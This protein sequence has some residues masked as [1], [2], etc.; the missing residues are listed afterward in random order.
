[1]QRKLRCIIIALGMYYTCIS[2]SGFAKSLDKQSFHNIF[3][4]AGYSSALCAGV[5]A[6][7]IGLSKQP[8]EHF[9][10][11]TIGASV[12]F[13]GGVALGTFMNI[14][15][16]VE[17]TTLGQSYQGPGDSEYSLWPQGVQ[18]N[19]TLPLW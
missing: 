9:N 19:F 16:S 11:I 15:T 10:Y 3:T 18:L 17:T 1:M 2:T 8:S 13:I 14:T 7:I 5:G 4:V 6:A 12:G